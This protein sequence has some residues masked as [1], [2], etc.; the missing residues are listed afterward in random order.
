MQLRNNGI[1]GDRSSVNCV[2][3]YELPPKHVELVLG[4]LHHGLDL[5]VPAHDDIVALSGEPEYS[6]A[7]ATSPFEDS[8]VR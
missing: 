3:H 1:A 2:E 4:E 5:T 6:E 7:R 8:P